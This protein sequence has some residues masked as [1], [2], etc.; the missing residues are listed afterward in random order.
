MPLRFSERSAKQGAMQ[1]SAVQALL[2]AVPGRGPTSGGVVLLAQVPVHVCVAEAL[3]VPCTH[4]QRAWL[5]QCN[6]VTPVAGSGWSTSQA[7]G[8]MM[9]ASHKRAQMK[10]RRRVGN[11]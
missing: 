9:F 5:W 1:A 11:L 8:C 6:L 3:Q 10:Q 4:Q 7:A 2:G